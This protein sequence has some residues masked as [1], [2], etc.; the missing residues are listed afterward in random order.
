MTAYLPK[1]WLS[2]QV[3]VMFRPEGSLKGSLF[4]WSEGG[5]FLH[6][7]EV[8][9]TRKLFIPWSSI[10]YVELLEQADEGETDEGEAT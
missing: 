9:R 10:R 7:V 2:K 1:G 5:V 4:S 6:I 8:E 3:V